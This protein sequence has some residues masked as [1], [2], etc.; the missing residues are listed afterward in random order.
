MLIHT[1]ELPIFPGYNITYQPTS[2]CMFTF[3]QRSWY[4]NF[5]LGNVLHSNNTIQSGLQV[6][7]KKPFYWDISKY[8]FRNGFCIKWDFPTATAKLKA[9]TFLSGWG[10]K[11]AV[12]SFWTTKT[13][14]GQHS[15]SDI[16]RCID[17][18]NALN[19]TSGLL[20]KEIHKNKTLSCND[21]I[22]LK[23]KYRK[24]A[25]SFFFSFF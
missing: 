10:E 8:K 16:F 13:I 25:F 24:N 15:K 17:T 4:L 12:P 9:I 20:I 23:T 22:F 1:T 5:C 6:N 14:N 3:F 21:H 7:F 2:V 19:L 18:G 11:K